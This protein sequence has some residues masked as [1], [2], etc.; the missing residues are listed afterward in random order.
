MSMNR[1]KRILTLLMLLAMPIA[2]RHAFERGKVD[3]RCAATRGGAPGGHL[4]GPRGQR[5]RG[6]RGS[7]QTGGRVAE[8]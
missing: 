5:L 4:R 2:V 3:V 6:H 1:I 7:E 8:H